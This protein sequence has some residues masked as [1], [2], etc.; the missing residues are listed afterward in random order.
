MQHNHHQNF[1]RNTFIWLVMGYIRD[2]GLYVGDHVAPKEGGWIKGQPGTSAFVPYTVIFSGPISL[3]QSTFMPGGYDARMTLMTRSFGATREQADTISFQ[4]R[5]ALSEKKPD[6]GGFRTNL[7]WPSSIGAADRLD[8]VDPKM[9][10]VV[11]TFT[12]E[13][14]PYLGKVT[15]PPAPKQSDHL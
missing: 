8:D 9:W 7:L 5:E 15:P 2:A 6:A 4:V 1:N 13:C 14:V 10:R 11:D 3:T 12:A